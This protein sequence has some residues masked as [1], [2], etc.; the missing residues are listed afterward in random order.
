MCLAQESNKFDELY[1]SL[2]FCFSDCQ[3]MAF[4]LQLYIEDTCPSCLLVE[5]P[6]LL[7]VIVSSSSLVFLKKLLV[8]RL[9]LL[10]VDEPN[11]NFKV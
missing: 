4:I 5:N 11:T 7:L 2:L 3:A 1:Q 6:R 8:V 10:K 9:V